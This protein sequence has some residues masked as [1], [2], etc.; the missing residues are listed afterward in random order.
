MIK[1]D[2]NNL[3]DLEFELQ[4][5][6]RYGAHTDC[7]FAKRVNLRWDVLPKALVEKLMNRCIGDSVDATFDAGEIIPGPDPTKLFRVKLSQFDNEFRPDA[8]IYPRQGRFYP[9]GILRD[10]ANVFRSNKEPFR[11]VEVNDS[12]ILVDFNHPLAGTEMHVKA[13]IREIMDNKRPTYRMG[14][15]VTDWMEAVTTGPGLQ[16]RWNGQSTDF[17]SDNAFARTDE[18]PDS[19]FYEKS[20]FVS[21]IDETAIE[22]ISALY[23][24]VINPGSSVL[25]LISG[26]KSHIPPHLKLGKVTGLGMNPE[27]LRKN[28]QL[29]DIA[30]HDLNEN[31]VLP[32]GDESFDAVICTVSVEYLTNPLAVFKEVGRILKHGGCFAL[33]FSNRWF[34]PKVINVWQQ[35]YEFERM[36][37]VSEYFL[38]SESFEQIHTYS[39]RGLPRPEGDRYYGE[40]L[41]SD[42]VY[43]VWA[44]KS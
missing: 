9:K 28:E 39:I 3:V 38:L 44:Y 6:S 23:G 35:I 43:G 36:G 14:L 25:D 17:F 16:I 31:T 26:W 12:D 21:H 15:M 37:L 10:V 30:I 29:T 34:S 5:K 2:I 33:T 4:W 13:T 8:I 32:F 41:L 7:F 20:R 11:C 42:P 24:K 22:N 19:H 27:E 40:L 1:T 18:A